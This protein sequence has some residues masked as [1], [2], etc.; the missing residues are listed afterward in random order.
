MHKGHFPA[1]YVPG[2]AQSAPPGPLG[3]RL[4]D[5]LPGATDTRSRRA[6]LVGLGA[7]LCTSA[8][9][10]ITVFQNRG[11]AGAQTNTN[12]NTNTT[13]PRRG[14]LAW[15]LAMGAASDTELVLA[16]GDLEM[17]SAQHRR[18]VRLVPVFERLL[19][20]TLG[21]DLEHADVAGACAVRSLARLGQPQLALRRQEAL[22]G[23]VRPETHMALDSVRRQY[24]HDHKRPR[25]RQ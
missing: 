13:P 23:L 15:A 14:T 12:A 18:E 4:L 7:F 6:W 24:G 5:D 3:P 9:A 19:D 20:I 2:K 17:V 11:V 8:V 21:R 1:R 22:T 25:R 16:S 10:A